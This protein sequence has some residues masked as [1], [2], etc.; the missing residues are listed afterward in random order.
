M[1]PSN[2]APPTPAD[3]ETALTALDIGTRARIAAIDGGGK[4]TRRLMGL[5]LRVG[6]EISVLQRRG[7]GVVV[8]SAGT[9][10]A[11]GGSIASRVITR[12]TPS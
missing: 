3:E 5:G 6:S 7:R 4:L 8:S 9:R 2:L 11:L 10:V 1:T 12:H